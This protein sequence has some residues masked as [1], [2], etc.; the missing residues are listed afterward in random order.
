MRT[1]RLRIA[2]PLAV[3]IAAATGAG[4]SVAPAN[5]ASAAPMASAKKCPRGTVRAVIGGKATCLRKGA[6]CKARYEH[7][8]RRHGFH[9]RNGRL[10]KLP[11]PLPP[12]SRPVASIAVGHPITLLADVTGVW[13]VATSIDSEL[14]RIDPATN[15]V[16]AQIPRT[17][18][19]DGFAAAGAGAIWETDFDANDLLR[20][21]PASNQVT[22]TIPLGDDAAPE[23]VA[24][25][26]GAIWVAD[27]HLGTVSRVD[28]L[29]NTV[30]ATVEVGPAGSSGPYEL[31]AGA[32]GLWVNT[33]RTAEVTHIDPATNSVVGRVE[34]SGP[35]ILD[36]DRV[37]IVRSF[38]LDVV[39]PATNMV[40][41]RIKLPETTGVGTAGFG[42]V[43][44]PTKSGLARVDEQSE[45][46]VG[47]ARGLPP[48]SMAVASADSIWLT[49]PT[50][51]KLLRYAPS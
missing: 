15:T 38:S 30:T 47:L 14:V 6:R 10:V 11:P 34:E 39:D 12:G 5:R 17:V 24:A 42:S 50:Q 48:C 19:S 25:A 3:A 13:V 36:G 43:W 40:V 7:A 2:V 27:H 46:L 23:G 21:D 45:K 49:S 28:P 35:P 41:K 9:C 1:I 20:V 37:W 18:F 4:A 44:V 31:A 29:T 8:Y 22:A 26:A 16:V 33:P 32:T 51:N